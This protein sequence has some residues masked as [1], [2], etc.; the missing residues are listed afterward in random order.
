MAKDI[1]TTQPEENTEAEALPITP[2]IAEKAKSNKPLI[3]GIMA[4][5]LVFSV[6]VVGFWA[7]NKF[8][9]SPAVSPGRVLPPN[10]L[11]YITI[12]PSP[13]ESQKKA[14]DEITR[15]FEAQPGFKEAWAK[16]GDG[17]AGSGVRDQWLGIG[18]FDS[19]SSYLGSNFTLGLLPPSTNDLERIRTASD[20]DEEMLDVLKRNVVGL[21]DLDFNPLNKKGPLADLKRHSEDG[22]IVDV[23]E[24][25]RDIEIRKYVS[26]TVTL[27][28]SL[29]P[30]TSTAV[31][32]ADPEPVRTVIDQFVLDEGLKYDPVYKE[33]LADLPYEQVVT[34][35]VS[36]T[37]ISHQLQLM[38]DFR[39]TAALEGTGAWMASL[40]GK[41]D[42]L[43]IN[44]VAQTEFEGTGMLLF[45]RPGI[46]MEVNPRARPQV[47]SLYDVPQDALAFVV[48]TDLKSTAQ[49][50][51]GSFRSE[52]PPG[53]AQMEAELKEKTSLDLKQD[54]LPIIG[55]DYI[56]SLSASGTPDN[57]IPLFVSQLK[58]SPDSRSRA[59]EVVPALMEAFSTGGAVVQTTEMGNSFY[60]PASSNTTVVLASDRLIQIQDEDQTIAKEKAR[61]VLAGIGEGFGGTDKW[62]AISKHLPV[63]SNLIAYADIKAIREIYERNM[64][65]EE[66]G[67]YKQLS[68][69]LR[70]AQYIL[71]GSANYSNLAT[72]EP[73]PISKLRSH[74]VVFVGIGD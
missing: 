20:G 42:G 46:D 31:V 38:Q 43:Q 26:D 59:L 28:F 57:P 7:Y 2:P 60:V 41:P 25:Y 19:L 15:A 11:A 67:E 65:E 72:K 12:D 1:H 10:T 52:D 4:M 61:T 16:L 5:V 50:A 6:A 23:T 27:Y 47:A 68:P 58:L 73:K 36:L 21:V 62:K 18:D 48:G 3:A 14:F 29:L 30:D 69:F 71:V 17:A 35:Y 66:E 32:G 40:S 51:L 45:G 33:L 9:N 34:I 63:D 70:P 74:T 49:V 24:K 8:L 55:G 37:E 22:V 53:E 56:V 64:S 13:G 39:D 54:I 44:I